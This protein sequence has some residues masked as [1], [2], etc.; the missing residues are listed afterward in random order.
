[1]SVEAMALALHHSRAAGTARLVLI[2][3]ANHD[4]DGGA[5]PSIATLAKYAGLNGKP[6]NNAKVVRRA[7]KTL[8]DLGEVTVVRQGGGTREMN[9]YE[10]PNLYR[11]TLRCPEGCDGSTKHK[12]PRSET[13][14]LYSPPGGGQGARGEGAEQPPKPSLQPPTESSVGSSDHW[15]TKPPHDQARRKPAKAK[16]LTQDEMN[17]DFARLKAL[18]LEE[19][20]DDPASV[21]W[22]LRKEHA[23]V[24]PAAFMARLIE[25]G[26]WTGFVGNHGIGEYQ[27][28]GEAA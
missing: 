1:V 12:M 10:R 28:N 7:V 9:D 5:W 19:G 24:S 20:Q 3:I 26:E 18:C 16:T 27:P 15:A 11:V 8:V 22:T 13:P 4:G 21:W 14:G 23:A 6:D 25:Y 2:G 17:A